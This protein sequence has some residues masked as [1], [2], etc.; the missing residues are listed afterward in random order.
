[1]VRCCL[2]CVV[3]CVLLF[4]DLFAVCCL[5]FVRC[6]LLVDG[7]L[8]AG[9]CWSLC[10]PIYVDVCGSLFVVGSLLFVL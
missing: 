1:M 10:V 7:C 6:L 8:V 4:V 3:S 2:L 9:C 5:L